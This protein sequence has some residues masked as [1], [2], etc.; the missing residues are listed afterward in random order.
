MEKRDSW[1]P[2]YPL[3]APYLPRRRNQTCSALDRVSYVSTDLAALAAS[4]ETNEVSSSSESREI[5]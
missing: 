5:K 1:P 3:V 4:H 2:T